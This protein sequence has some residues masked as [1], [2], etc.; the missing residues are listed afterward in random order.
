MR[1]Q[2]ATSIDEDAANLFREA[3]DARGIKMNTVL[4]AFMMEFA[5]SKFSVE[6]KKDGM[7]LHLDE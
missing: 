2:F 5:E 4:E 1:K 6:I 7:K 3:C